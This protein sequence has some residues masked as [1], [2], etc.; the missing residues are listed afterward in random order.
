MIEAGLEPPEL[1]VEIRLP[2]GGVARADDLWRRAGVVGEFDGRVR[3]GRSWPLS[4]L[5]PGEVVEREKS[6]GA[7]RG[8]G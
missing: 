2:D 6:R 3:C 7:R 4:G 5:P 1:Q 8:G